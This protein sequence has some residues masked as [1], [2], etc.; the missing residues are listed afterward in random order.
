MCPKNNA[1]TRSAAEQHELGCPLP[2][3]VVAEME[4]IRNW[5][6]MPDNVSS[7]DIFIRSLRL[8]CMSTKKRSRK[9]RSFKRFLAGVFTPL[10]TPGRAG[11]QMVRVAGV[12][13]TTCGFGGRHSIQLSYTRSR[14]QIPKHTYYALNRVHGKQNRRACHR[15]KY[16]RCWKGDLCT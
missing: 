12:E 1:A 10:P 13:P 4:S 2:A 15:H 16:G 9:K 5:F 11:Q 14:L 8:Y 3:A 6:A 7:V